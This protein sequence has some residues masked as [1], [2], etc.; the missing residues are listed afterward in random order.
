[1]DQRIVYARDGDVWYDKIINIIE[2]FVFTS[3]NSTDN[4]NSDTENDSNDDTEI[5]PEFD[6]RDKEKYFEDFSRSS[7]VKKIIDAGYSVGYDVEPTQ[8]VFVS[9][10]MLSSEFANTD[11]DA[12]NDGENE[13]HD[14]YNEH[15]C[16]LVRVVKVVDPE[17]RDV[18]GNWGDHIIGKE[19][20]ILNK[21]QL[22]V[23]RR[24][25][26]F[27]FDKCAFDV[28]KVDH[29]SEGQKNKKFIVMISSDVLGIHHAA[30]M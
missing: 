16:K 4:I 12:V 30:S 22:K 13:L 11:Y 23:E 5:D 7:K 15:E 8:T 27:D 14:F 21:K 10:A 25:V 9:Q 3:S 1:M 19:K 18:P 26:A 6:Y 20:K 29:E 28:K 2:K 17:P 24:Y